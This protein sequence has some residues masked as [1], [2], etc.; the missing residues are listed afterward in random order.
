[1]YGDKKGIFLFPID[2]GGSTKLLESLTGFAEKT[3]EQTTE[4][5]ILALKQQSCMIPRANE[6]GDAKEL[7]DIGAQRVKTVS[8]EHSSNKGKKKVTKK[9]L[10]AW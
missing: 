6:I 4:E 5:W 7:C 8:A 1:M 10:M 2:I 9:K 3:T